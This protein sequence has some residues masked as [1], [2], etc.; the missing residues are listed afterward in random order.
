MFDFIRQI[1]EVFCFNGPVDMD[2]FYRDGVYYLSEINP[3]FGGAYLHG[4]GAGADFPKLIR[5]NIHGIENPD[6]MGNYED[7]SI[8]LMYDDVIMTNQKELKGDY[9]S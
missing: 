5:N 1:C 6:E 7:A 3:R 4:Y 8:M 9:R 2:F